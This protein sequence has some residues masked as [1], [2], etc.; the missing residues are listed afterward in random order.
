MSCAPRRAAAIWPVDAPLR[1]ESHQPM[2]E[3][4]TIMR[5]LGG[6]LK[7]RPHVAVRIRG[8]VDEG[9]MVGLG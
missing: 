7:D 3:D 1:Q 4:G 9:H 2:A 5:W 8:W 6:H